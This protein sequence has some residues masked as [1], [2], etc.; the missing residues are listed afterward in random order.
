MNNDQMSYWFKACQSVEAMNIDNT[1]MAF[2]R[3]M[4][5]K[6]SGKKINQSIDKMRNTLT[7][8]LLRK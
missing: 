6:E 4:G 8:D 1:T 3:V 5:D 7:K 2:G